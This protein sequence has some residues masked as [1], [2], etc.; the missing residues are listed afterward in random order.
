MVKKVFGESFAL[1][2]QIDSGLKCIILLMND[3][4]EARDIP[5]FMITSDGTRR[6][7]FFQGKIF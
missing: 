7:L 6:K 4:G 5:G 3:D 2:H 1:N